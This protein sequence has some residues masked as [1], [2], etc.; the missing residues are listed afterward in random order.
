MLVNAWWELLSSAH[1]NITQTI[2]DT[3]SQWISKHKSE[4]RNYI[5][6]FLG[7]LTSLVL[8]D[9]KQILNHSIQHLHDLGCPIQGQRGQV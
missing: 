3:A 7:L 5:V 6:T 8:I 1:H 9:V 4:V 2:V